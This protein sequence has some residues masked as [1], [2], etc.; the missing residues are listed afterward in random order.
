MSKATDQEAIFGVVPMIKSEKKYGFIDTLLIT[1]GYAI[2]TWCYTQGAFMAQNLT[3]KQLIASVF[4]PNI[5]FITL[6]ALPAIFAVRYGVDIW[7][8]MRSIFGVTANR[9]IAVAVIIMVLPW[10]SVCADIFAGSMMRLAEELGFG[11]A[12]GLRPVVALVCVLLGM[13]IALGGPGTIRLTNRFM[14]SALLLVGI[15]AT[16][17]AFTA[18]P[19]ESITSFTPAT[20]TKDTYALNIEAS[21][22][23]AISWAMGVAVIPRLCNNER[24][25]YWAT[26]ISYGVVAPFF[27]FTGGVLSLAM[28][29]KTG[30]FTDD[31]TTILAT[32]GGPKLA[33]LSLLL[34]AIANI[35]T[36]G[37]GTYIYSMILKAVF[38]NLKFKWFAFITTAYMAV[39]TLWGGV[40]EYF[41]AF[42]S[43]S[44]FLLAPICGILIVDYFFIRK[45]KVSLRALY[46]SN[47]SFK[48]IGFVSVVLGLVS[49]ALVY[50]PG[51]GEIL[52][53]VFYFTTSSGLSF[54]V[55]SVSYLVLSFV[56]AKRKKN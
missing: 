20:Y 53:P 27:V 29:A 13:F 54:I 40:V 25:G 9:V 23:F 7:V 26:S 42:I 46:D 15:I 33:L 14:V 8:W 28:F 19:L 4:G 10:F 55:G 47:K 32:L 34:V 43:Y 35:G 37:T 5:L 38:P 11:I 50:N 56:M 18:V 48:P 6:I 12:P 1:S 2:A 31:P 45:Q 16:V 21:V 51:T 52:S 39:L 49:G 41:G 3:F 22:A 44:A 30:I 36:A 24:K 17:V